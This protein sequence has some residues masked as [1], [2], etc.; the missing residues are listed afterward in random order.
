MSRKRLGP[1]EQHDVAPGTRE[2][3]ADKTA[4][5]A[6]TENCMSHEH[7]R[8]Y[9][10]IDATQDAKMGDEQ[11]GVTVGCGFKGSTQTGP[12]SCVSRAHARISDTAQLRKNRQPRDRLISCKSRHRPRRA[13]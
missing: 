7:N 5:T 2:R 12:S 9:G 8:K 6:R 10:N 1:Q 13:T 11:R 4:D 3:A